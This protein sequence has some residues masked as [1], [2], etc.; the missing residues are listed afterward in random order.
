MIN[1][2]SIAFFWFFLSTGKHYITKVALEDCNLV[3][4][5]K[6]VTCE[7]CRKVRDCIRVFVIFL[8]CGVFLAIKKWPSVQRL[9]F[10]KLK[11]PDVNDFLERSW[12]KHNIDCLCCHCTLELSIARC[13]F[14]LHIATE[15]NYSGFWIVF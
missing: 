12:L 15:F 10:Q 4:E 1:F 6:A 8:C 3:E 9:K 2:S 14:L 7:N 11:Y 5:F 13:F